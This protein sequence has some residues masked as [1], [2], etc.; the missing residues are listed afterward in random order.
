MFLRRLRNT[1]N[2]HKHLWRPKCTIRTTS[3]YVEQLSYNNQ[4]D[5]KKRCFEGAYVRSKR[6]VALLP[7]PS[8]LLIYLLKKN[9][10]YIYFNK[11]PNEKLDTYLSDHIFLQ[12]NI[13]MLFSL[14]LHVYFSIR[15]NIEW[16][17]FKVIK[18]M[19]Y[20]SCDNSILMM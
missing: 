20:Y 7:L 3:P 12:L 18:F 5:F 6:L 19:H 14:R 9:N 10:K 11:K 8:Q 4:V 16:Y 13:V 2:F 17:W 15:Y 1:K